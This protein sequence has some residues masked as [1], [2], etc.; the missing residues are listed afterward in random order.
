[1]VIIVISQH[2]NPWFEFSPLVCSVVSLYVT[3]VSAELSSH[4]PKTL[5][6]AQIIGSMNKLDEVTED[7]CVVSQ[8]HVC[9]FNPCLVLSKT[10]NTVSTL[11]L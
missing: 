3:S 11:K 9:E 4:N 10:P 6:E 1:M 5:F 7:K 2:E 8:S